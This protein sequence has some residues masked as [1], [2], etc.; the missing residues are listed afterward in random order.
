MAFCHSQHCSTICYEEGEGVRG[1]TPCEI[2]LIICFKYYGN[3]LL[4]IKICPFLDRKEK[5]HLL[6][7]SYFPMH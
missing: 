3:A 2:S 6:F 1:Q 7:Q 5:L 4:D